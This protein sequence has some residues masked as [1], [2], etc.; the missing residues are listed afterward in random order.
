MAGRLLAAGCEEAAV[1]RDADLVVINTC[2]IRE[3][4][5]QKVIGRQGQL[6][7]AQGREPGAARRADRL[8]GARAGS[9]RPAAALPGGRPV[10][11][12]RRGARARRPARAGVGP[13]ADRGA[14]GATHRR[15]GA[16]SSASPTTWP[17]PGPRPSGSGTVARGSAIARLAADHL[18]LRQ[19]LH[20]LHRAVQPRPGAE[21]AVRRD[22]RRG[23]VARRRRLSRGHAARPE[24]QLVRPRP[25]RRS[26]ASPTST[27]SA[28]PAAGSTS[29]GRPDLAELIRAIDGIR[30]ADGQPAIARLRFVTSHPWDLS[31]RLI[32]AHGRLPVGLRAPP[33][34]GPVG[35]RRGPPADGPPVHDRALPR[36]PGPDPRGRARDRD[37]DRRHRRVLRRDRG[38]V[39]GDAAR[40]SR[41]SATT[42]SSP[43]P[44]RER[45]GHAGDAPRRR[46]P[47]GRQAAPA[48]R[49]ARASRR[50]SGSS[51][52][53]AWLGREV[54]VLVDAVDPP[55][56]ARPRRREPRRPGGRGRRALRAD[57]R[58]QARPPG[59]RRGRS[60]GGRSRVRIDHAGPYALRGALVGA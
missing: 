41:P 24:R 11:A 28:G 56:G 51:A 54:E 25:R 59:R 3:G 30:T 21:P 7:A 60:S 39:R 31:D 55:R 9:G 34:A 8:L 2:A 35:R 57:A 13:G 19:D 38:P 12:A 45:P 49:A 10:P 17:R 47:G 33:P 42:R 58:Q 44:T 26:R 6:A 32:A 52:T 40:C 37:L 48:Q 23:A 46:R 43:R 15:S 1:A 20:L 29:H 50:R 14:S 5:E 16:R 36:A 18:R 4:A 53:E 22:R 27:P